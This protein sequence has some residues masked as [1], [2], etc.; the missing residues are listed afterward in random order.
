M[1]HD[2]RS[3]PTSRYSLYAGTQ[4]MQLCSKPCFQPTSRTRQPPRRIL[5]ISRALGQCRLP[6]AN[7]PLGQLTLIHPALH[8]AGRQFYGISFF[9]DPLMATLQ[10]STGVFK[11]LQRSYPSSIHIVLRF[12]RD[13]SSVLYCTPLTAFYS[14][15]TYFKRAQRDNYLL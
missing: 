1:V 9:T 3:I 5:L 2:D 6:P 15:F 4:R 8:S 12:L 14:R 11:D 10:Q 7:L 13:V